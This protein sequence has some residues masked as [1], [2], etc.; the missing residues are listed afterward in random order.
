MMIF[1]VAVA[2]TLTAALPTG[3]VPA[4][5][6]SIPVVKTWADLLGQRPIDLGGGAKLRLGTSALECPRWSGVLVYALTEGFDDSAAYATNR[7]RLGPVWVSVSVD[8]LSLDAREKYQAAQSRR[9]ALLL[10]EKAPHSRRLLFTRLALVDRAGKYRITVRGEDGKP[11]AAAVVT[12]TD[13]R[14]APYHPWTPLLLVA[15]VEYA[16]ISADSFEERVV[17]PAVVTKLD[18]G[19]ALP[20]IWSDVGLDAPRDDAAAKAPLPG[21]IP[22]GA[23]QLRLTLDGKTLLL[24]MDLGK[25]QETW[26]PDWHLLAR[27]WVNGKPCLPAPADELPPSRAGAEARPDGDLLVQ[28]RM[29]ARKFGARSGDKVELQLLYCPNGWALVRNPQA[30]LAAH[31]QNNPLFGVMRPEQPGFAVLTNRVSFTV[32]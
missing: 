13:R 21:I 3:E 7:D 4:G 26:G 12:G 17:R 16:P 2:L 29:D 18:V 30:A 1:S 27:W 20:V 23:R 31:G 5:L 14:A 25:D 9:A 15:P 19:M 32:P 8:G 6:Q 28:L 24:R 22:E 11:L 10:R